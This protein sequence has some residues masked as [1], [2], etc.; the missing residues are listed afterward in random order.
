MV[1]TNIILP[2]DAWKC[3]TLNALKMKLY[4]LRWYCD[5]IIEIGRKY[6]N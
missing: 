5:E 2:S 3:A 1:I 4:T 6:Y